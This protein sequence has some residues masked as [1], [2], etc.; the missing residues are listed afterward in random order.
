[1]FSQLRQHR[2]ENLESQILFVSQ[3]VSSPL[4]DT[5]FVVQPF[6][7]SQRDFVFRSAVSG[8]TIPMLLDHLRELLIG[9]KPLPFERRLPVLK[10][11][12]R[13]T[14]AL[15]A[16]QLTEG[17]LKQVGGVESLVGTQQGLE[18]LAAF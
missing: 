13:P 3:S 6:N 16:P 4:Y 1:M 12:P 9:S 15:V 17:L 18:R 7:E 5:N 10:E 8:D 14:F 11:A 2:S